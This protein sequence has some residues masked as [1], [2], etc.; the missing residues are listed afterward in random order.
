MINF[1]HLKP[2]MKLKLFYGEGNINNKVMHI[3]AVIDNE[4]FV[5][6]FWAKHK[7]AWIYQIEHESFFFVRDKFI[8]FI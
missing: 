6:K 1:N 4:Y 2:G 7:K 8:S 5:Y 3:R